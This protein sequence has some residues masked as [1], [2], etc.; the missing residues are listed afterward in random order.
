MTS[1]SR[2][3]RPLVSVVLPTHNRVDLLAGAVESVLSQTEQRFEL[4]IVDDGSRDATPEYLAAL[5]SRDRRTRSI[6]FETPRGGAGA[7][8]E[9]IRVSQGDWVA[10]LDDDDRWLPTKLEK[11][12]T[13]LRAHPTAVA[14]SCGYERVFASRKRQVV[15]VPASVKLSD[16]FESNVLGSASLCLG[17]AQA[18]CSIAGFDTSLVAGQ[19]LDLWV[20][21]RQLGEIVV[22]GEPLVLYHVHDGPRITNNM[23]SQYAGSRRFYFKHRHL[24]DGAVR[25][26]RIAHASFLMS[27]QEQRSLHRRIRL[28]LIAIRNAKLGD[29]IAYA[30]SS[31][32]RLL[33]DAVAR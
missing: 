6:R 8:N 25:R 13:A 3:E 23:F 15:A 29:A 9:G 16:L 30:R 20:R 24:M 2:R 22:C 28:L 1:E 26:H 32:P 27:R 19:D 31:L 17:S 7:R 10:F 18:L 33:R 21:L 11:Q 4:I 5:T 12:L 14:A